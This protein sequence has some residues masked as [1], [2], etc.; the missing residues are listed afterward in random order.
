LLELL[1]EAIT[2]FAAAFDPQPFHLDEAVIK[3]RATTLNQR[4]EVVQ[5]FVGNLLVRR[6]PK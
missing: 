6:R 2:G 4:D 1:K 3:V 5:P